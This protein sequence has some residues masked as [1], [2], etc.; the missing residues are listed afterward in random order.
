MV[1]GA[2]D[3]DIIVGGSGDFGHYEALH[4]SKSF[5][6]GNLPDLFPSDIKCR[7]LDNDNA[8]EFGRALFRYNREPGNFTELHDVSVRGWF[9]VGTRD[10]DSHAGVVCRADSSVPASTSN[11]SRVS[12]NGYYLALRQKWS[13]P[14]VSLTLDRFKDSAGTNLYSLDI[15]VGAG[16]Y[17]WFGLRVD[18]LLQ[19]DNSAVVRA[20]TQSVAVPGWQEAFVVEEPP[21]AIPAHAGVGWGGQ[22][23]GGGAALVNEA[24]VDLVE[25]LHSV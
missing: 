2:T 22:V 11:L 15:P 7:R 12:N 19:S 20:Y 3:W 1:V 10:A 13:V 8:T 17:S 24:Y 14:G 21:E 6:G 23:E 5:S 16:L 18:F 25:V 4:S 9:S